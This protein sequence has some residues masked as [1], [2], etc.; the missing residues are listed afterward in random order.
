MQPGPTHEMV[1]KE[2]LNAWL[3]NVLCVTGFAPELHTPD[4]RGRWVDTLPA[5]IPDDLQKFATASRDM[6]SSFGPTLEAPDDVQMAFSRSLAPVYSTGPEGFD[7]ATVRA[8]A[9]CVALFEVRHR[10]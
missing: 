7:A 2:E 4:W 10:R 8:H 1:A 9:S 6:M 5:E 3:G